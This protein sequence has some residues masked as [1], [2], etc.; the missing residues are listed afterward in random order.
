MSLSRHPRRVPVQILHNIFDGKC[1]GLF[2]LLL[3]ASAAHAQN[4]APAKAVRENPP[5]ADEIRVSAFERQ[6]REGSV[7]RLRG[8][9]V[10]ETVEMRLRADEVDYDEAKQYAEARGNV[11]FTHFERGE[12]IEA[13][14]V[15]YSIAEETGR[16]YKVHGT[17]PAKIESRPGVLTTANPFTFEGEWAERRKDRYILHDGTITNCRVPN[18]W[19]TLRGPTFDVIPGQRAI[20]RNSV[21]RLRG[22]PI[23][24]TP[25]FFKSLERVPRRSGFLTPNIGNSSRRGRMLGG[26]YYWAINRSYDT[27]YRA[28]WFTQRG[29]AHHVDFRGKPTQRSDFNFILYGVND[30]GRPDNPT[31]KEGGYLMTVEGRV[32]L[33][34]GF[35]GRAD[36]NYLSSYTFRRAFTESFYEAIHTQ[37]HAI[38][39]V[40]RNW[41]TY[42]LHT[43]YQSSENFISDRENDSVSIR[44]L[45]SVE[46]NSRDRELRGG[47]LPVWLSF[48]SSLSLLRRNQLAFQT[49]RF[50]ERLDVYPRLTTAVRWKD[51]H[52]IPSFAVRETNY[53][54]SLADTREVIGRG[55]LRSAQEVSVELRM[56][57]LARVYDAKGWLGPKLKHVIE[58]RA[59]YRLVRGIDDFTRYVRFDETEI[60]SN[61]NETE[62]ALTNRFYA[63][64][65]DGRVEEIIS[66]DVAH[67]RYF[68]TTFGGAIREGVPN[69]LLS[70]ARLTGFTFYDQA[71]RYSPIVSTLRVNPGTIF[72]AEWRADYDPLRSTVANS[73][74]QLY[75]R[76][77][78][79]SFSAGHNQLD[80]PW[81]RANQIITQAGYGQ[82]NRQGWSAAVMSLY[83][84]RTRTLA[85]A[86]TQFTYNTDCCGFSVQFRVFDVGTRQETQFRVALAVANIGSFGTLRRQ[87]RLF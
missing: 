41:S 83:D 86:N 37:V 2:A 32:D 84:Y 49:R 26:G 40:T 69:V 3:V 27:T 23:F 8:N 48:D 64:R 87:E 58:P 5:A 1:H 13:E 60:F 73:T 19:W 76:L 71:R 10:I 66:W 35:L 25:Y 14:R 85:F 63:K 17:S 34:K 52:L 68:D 29:V 42:S 70:G 56:P 16:F 82:E 46:F 51:W 81:A 30:K 72:S 61:T 11:H 36:I 22:V 78:Q 31:I 15:E 55:L 33:G 54:S 7:Y 9:V 75:G 74:F 45:P 24:Y 47:A 12:N 18:P 65:T 80:V 79:W 50:V 21:F 77:D 59:Q 4:A 38:G 39:Y 62:V 53:G 57:S 20:A 44:K 43:L 67:Q 28:Q 6:D